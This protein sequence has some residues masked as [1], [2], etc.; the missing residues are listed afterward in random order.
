MVDP[1]ADDTS[2]QLELSKYNMS[3]A[4]G[5]ISLADSKAT[6]LLTIALVGL[7]TSLTNIPDATTVC[8]HYLQSESYLIPS[9][10]IV[11][12]TAFYGVLLYGIWS[13][14]NVIKPR[15]VPQS[16]RHSWF[17][18]QSMAQLSAEDFQRFNDSLDANAKL[19]QLNDQVYN[20]S[21]VARQKYGDV[22]KSVRILVIAAGLGILSVVPILILKVIVAAP[23]A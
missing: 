7:G 3:L 5:W 16:E 10:L 13:L 23:K 19:A 21:V 9:V 18:F 22:A 11:V 12:H 4:V 17:F 2:S 8:Q 14:V 1:I 15:L 6:F 20:N